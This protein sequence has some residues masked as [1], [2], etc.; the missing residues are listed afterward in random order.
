MEEENKKLKKAI[1]ELKETIS[2]LKSKNESLLK[3]QNKSPSLS[4]QTNKNSNSLSIFNSPKKST[5]QTQIE[6]ST[7]S[8]KYKTLNK[9]KTNTDIL[10]NGKSLLLLKKIQQ[11][12]KELSKQIKDFSHKNTQLELSLKGITS[13]DTNIKNHSS[14]LYS[15]TKNTMGELKNIE[16]KYRLNK[17]K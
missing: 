9:T 17:N 14:L 13:G 1:E 8:K 6:F 12:N 3:T 5:N 2:I 7:T 4:S 15:F 10:I 16:K 11:E